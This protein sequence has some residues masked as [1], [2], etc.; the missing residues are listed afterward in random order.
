M[1]LI[2]YFT[3]LSI[4]NDLEISQFQIGLTV[5][6]IAFVFNSVLSGNT[7][8]QYGSDDPPIYL[9]INNNNKNILK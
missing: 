2:Y 1:I 4:L 3:S 6:L 5:E 9:F 8:V 7:I